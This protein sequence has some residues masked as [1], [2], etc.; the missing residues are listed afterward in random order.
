MFVLKIVF[1]TIFEYPVQMGNY[2]GLTFLFDLSAGRQMSQFIL[3]LSA[4][5]CISVV[6]VFQ[7]NF[8]FLIASYVPIEHGASNSHMSKCI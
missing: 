1:Q 8:P 3:L 4:K 2:H 7:W 5:L 6:L